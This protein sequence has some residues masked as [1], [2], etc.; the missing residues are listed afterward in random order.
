M[1]SNLQITTSQEMQ[2]FRN[3]FAESQSLPEITQE[4][5]CVMK[6]HIELGSRV[7][8]EVR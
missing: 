6:I 3:N 1:T 5:D 2:G 4:F 8:G 7:G